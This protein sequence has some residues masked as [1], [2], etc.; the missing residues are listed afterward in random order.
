MVILGI[1]I[2]GMILFWFAKRTL[3]QLWNIVSFVMDFLMLPFG[4]VGGCLWAVLEIVIA[5]LF[6]GLCYWALN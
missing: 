1:I 5:L 4:M 3:P 2:G 6:I